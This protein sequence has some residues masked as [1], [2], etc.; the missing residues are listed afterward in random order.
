[1]LVFLG[2]AYSVPPLRFKSIPLV[3]I[4]THGLFFGTLLYL[5]GA[6]VAGGPSAQTMIVGVSIFI[7]S[8]TLELRNHLDDFQDPEKMC[9]SS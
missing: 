4:I 1:M 5:Y 2:G 6:L 8:I 7:Y 3:D 9:Q